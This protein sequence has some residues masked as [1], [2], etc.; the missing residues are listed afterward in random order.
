MAA[1]VPRPPRTSGFRQERSFGHE[2]DMEP[3][4]ST[5]TRRR[6]SMR[7]ELHT[8]PRTTGRMA[9]AAPHLG[10]FSDESLDTSSEDDDD[11]DDESDEDESSDVSDPSDK[12]SE[13][14]DEASLRRGKKAREY[15]SGTSEDDDD[16]DD[17]YDYEIDEVDDEEDEIPAPKKVYALPENT[18]D[19]DEDSPSPRP[20][21]KLRN[22]RR[23]ARKSVEDHS[24]PRAI[25]PS[26]PRRRRN[27][28]SP[29]R[30]PSSRASTAAAAE[31]MSEISP[32]K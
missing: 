25:E 21:R 10:N 9:E 13:A 20:R 29:P 30:V 22:P 2:N 23:Q 18:D 24:T 26:S 14:D 8:R 6:H 27:A 16:E 1:A 11:D 31:L 7:D 28:S 12:E 5:S 15:L 19:D 4:N 32:K 3:R 17:D